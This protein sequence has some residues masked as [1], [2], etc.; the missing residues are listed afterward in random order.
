MVIKRLT[1]FMLAA[2]CVFFASCSKDEDETFSVSVT[3][4][5]ETMGI[6]S[7]GGSFP[8]DAEII[9]KAEPK[10]GFYFFK[11]DDNNTEN[12]RKVTVTKDMA[13]IASFKEKGNGGG[14]GTGDLTEQQKLEGSMSENKTLKDLGLPID[15]IVDGMLT[16]SGNACLTIEPGVT[17]AF[18]GTNGIVSVDENAGLK[19]VGTAEKPITFTGPVNNQNKGAWGYIEYHSNRSD[20]QMEYVI[21]KNGGSYDG[22]GVLNTFDAGSVSVKNCTIDGGM[23]FGVQTHWG[24]GKNFKAFENNTIKNVAKAPMDIDAWNANNIGSGNKFEENGENYIMMTNSIND[25]KELILN[26]VDIPYYFP[27]GFMVEGKSELTVNAG[28]KLVF[29]KNEGMYTNSET[30]VKFEGTE[31]SPITL[32]GLESKAGYWKGVNH[33]SEEDECIFKN[34]VISDGDEFGLKLDCFDE[35][36]KIENL[37]IKNIKEYGL[38]VRTGTKEEEVDGET[39]YSRVWSEAFPG[40]VSGL[41]FENCGKGN[42]YDNN[43]LD[44]ETEGVD[45]VFETIPT[46]K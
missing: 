28:V 36:L 12:P 45:N 17:I 2:I 11:W 35:V 6:V 26:N 40:G 24:N 39:V 10:E 38:I 3:S 32:C 14:D 29:G 20:N 42:I 31:A 37:T 16:I 46:E 18:T 9:I 43:T 13:F 1:S 25:N 30:V 8:K 27:N 22:Y 7:G 15:Y 41:K 33:C 23:G 4:A 21:L 5:D 44:G 19:M 34:V